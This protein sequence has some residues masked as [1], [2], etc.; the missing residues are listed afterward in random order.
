MAMIF[1]H[2]AA[3]FQYSAGSARPVAEVGGSWRPVVLG[4]SPKAW[5]SALWSLASVVA[6]RKWRWAPYLVAVTTRCGLVVGLGV[7]WCQLLAAKS[8]SR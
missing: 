3:C 6:W 1:S 8:E 5:C 2:G 4:F 7:A